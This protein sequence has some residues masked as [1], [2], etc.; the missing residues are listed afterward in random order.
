[1]EAVWKVRS[2][3]LG[4]LL[5]PIKYFQYRGPH[6]GWEKQVF[7]YIVNKHFQQ[8]FSSCENLIAFCVC[9][10]LRISVSGSY[11]DSCQQKK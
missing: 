4:G 7:Y 1:M 9:V 10:Y 2:E 5:E 3:T 11:W 8:K 6:R